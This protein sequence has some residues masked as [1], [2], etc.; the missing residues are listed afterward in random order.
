MTHRL[1][2]PRATILTLA[3]VASLVPLA[4]GATPGPD[5]SPAGPEVPVTLAPEDTSITIGYSDGTLLGRLPLVIAEARGYLREAGFSEVE[6]VE[7]EEPLPGLLN[8]DLDLAFLDAR[9]A[10]E[11]YALGLPVRAI[12]GH[13]V[14]P[15]AERPAGCP[16]Q[17]PGSSPWGALDLIV[18][19]T[20]TVATRPGT[21]A[22][23]TLAYVRALGDLRA[24]ALGV[25]PYPAPSPAMTPGAAIPVTSPGATA[26]TFGDP[27]LDAAAAA[28]LEVTPDVLMAWPSPLEAFRPFDGGFD[29]AT[30]GDGLGSLRNLYLGDPGSMPDLGSFVA[31][32][33]LHAAQ[34]A[35]GLAPDPP[36]AAVTASTSPTA[37]GSARP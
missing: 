26:V 16:C 4:A 28:G 14:G 27:I 36:D 33:T 34:A 2:R 20:D 1:P 25:D 15:V 35:L 12:A 23:F 6:A 9:Q 32:R 5:A 11:A 17:V 22:A 13:R 10:I 29:D 19:T 21:V 31:V 37:I 7:V 18:T 24:R 30:G 8:G 3:L